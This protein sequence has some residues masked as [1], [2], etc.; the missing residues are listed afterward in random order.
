[1]T[2]PVVLEKLNDLYIR[3][4]HVRTENDGTGRWMAHVEI[5]VQN[6]SDRKQAAE[7]L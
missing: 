2:R 1:M 3:Q 7:L 5:K 6:L 4:M